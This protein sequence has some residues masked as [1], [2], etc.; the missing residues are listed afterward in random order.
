MVTLTVFG[1]IRIMPPISKEHLT[2][3]FELPKMKSFKSFKITG[4]IYFY[5][6]SKRVVE[7]SLGLP[8]IIHS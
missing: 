1:A 5:L 6:F 3:H 4:M 2:L 8:H 7:F